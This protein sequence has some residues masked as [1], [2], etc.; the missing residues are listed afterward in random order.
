M[1][2]MLSSVA[3]HD[4]ERSIV[5]TEGDVEADNRLAGLDQV[6]V[7][8]RDTGLFGGGFVEELDLLKE[9][10]FTELIDLRSEAG[11]SFGGLGV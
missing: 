6:K 2:G 3:C 1:G 9:T 4:L 7:F 8:V 10:R 11:S 5:S